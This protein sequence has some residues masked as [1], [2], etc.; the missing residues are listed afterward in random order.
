MNYADQSGNIKM[1]EMVALWNSSRLSMKK[2]LFRVS[3]NKLKELLTLK[4]NLELLMICL[5]C[6][7]IESNKY[8]LTE[9]N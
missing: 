6:V 5:A 2:Q 3:S 7:G 8:I 1:L 4:L 9:I